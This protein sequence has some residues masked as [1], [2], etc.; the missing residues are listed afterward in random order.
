MLGYMSK[1][2]YQNVVVI[3]S[4]TLL[5]F[6]YDFKMMRSVSI[7]FSAFS[8]SPKEKCAFVP[9]MS[10]IRS[11]VNLLPNTYYLDVCPIKCKSTYV[12]PSPH[13]HKNWKYLTEVIHKHLFKE[14]DHK[15]NII[16]NATI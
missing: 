15:K 11:S 8:A 7:S 9:V 16:Q 6:K 5:L 10:C 4:F 13:V 14:V 12:H 2:I 1:K 3:H